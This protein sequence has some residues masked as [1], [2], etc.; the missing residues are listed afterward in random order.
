MAY[1]EGTSHIWRWQDL[2]KKEINLRTEIMSAQLDN[3]IKIYIHDT[4]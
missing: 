4:L 1:V 3:V 2:Q